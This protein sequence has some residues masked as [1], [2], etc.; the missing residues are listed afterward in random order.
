MFFPLFSGRLDNLMAA[1]TA[2]PDEIPTRIPSVFAISLPVL[3]ASSSSM[4]M[5]SSYMSVFNVS[6]INPAPIPCIL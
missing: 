6:G 1:A 3:K 4:A 2:A 5:T